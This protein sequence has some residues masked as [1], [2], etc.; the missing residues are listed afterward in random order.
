MEARK[1]KLTTGGRVSL[2]RDALLS[3]RNEKGLSQEIVAHMC[4]EQR[5]CV[6]IASLKRAET[7]KNILYRTARDISSF[8]DVALSDLIDTAS[9]ETE[10]LSSS[11]LNG[12]L[13]INAKRQIVVLICD[14]ILQHEAAHKD[15]IKVWKST[16]DSS[17]RD[18]DAS[19]IPLSSTRYAF[20]FGNLAFM[21][22]EHYQA[23]HCGKNLQALMRPT[24]GDHGIVVA[25]ISYQEIIPREGDSPSNQR[26]ISELLQ[27]WQCDLADCSE[28]KQDVIIANEPARQALE[29]RYSIS[30]YPAK[31]HNA[32]TSHWQIHED[33][34]SQM[35][36]KHFIGRELQLQQFKAAV[37]SVFAYDEMQLIYIRG[38]AGIGKTRALEAFCEYANGLGMDAHKAQVLDFGAEQN[39]TAI[40]K[41][42]RSILKLSAEDQNLSYEEL[43]Q[44]FGQSVCEQQD[45]IFL[46]HWLGWPLSGK[47]A[48]LYKTMDHESRTAGLKNVVVELIQKS[49]QQFP[50]LLCIEDLHWANKDLLESIQDLAEAIKDTQVILLMTSRRENDPMQGL[51]SSAWLNT[52]LLTMDLTPLRDTEATTFADY[53]D[54][55]PANYKQQCIQ[56]ADGNPLFLEQL[57]RA[58]DIHSENLPHNLQTLI[59]ARLD[60][61]SAQSQRAARAASVLGQW[62]TQDALDFV[63]DAQQQ[64]T[65][66]LINN[67]IVKH[68]G[69]R[70]QFVHALVQQGIYQTITDDALMELHQRC[71]QWFESSDI[72]LQAQHLDRARVKQA[73]AVYLLAIKHN[74]EHHNFDKALQLI[75]EAEQINYTDVD[76]SSLWRYK[77]E[78]MVATGNTEEAVACF[79]KSIA[80]A[81]T[82]HDKLSPLLSL[83]N[84]LD[85]LEQFEDALN[86]L[87][88]AEACVSEGNI[89]RELSQ[90]HYLR[91][92]LYFPR[93][94]VDYC[95]QEHSK[96]LSYAR[97]ANDAHAEAK[98]L[99]GLGDAAYAQGKMLSAYKHFRECL[100]LCAEFNLSSVEAANRLM[101]GTTRIYLNET[102]QALE[103]ALESAEIARTVGHKRAEIVSRL[104]AGWILLDMQSLSQASEQIER[105]LTLARDIGAKRFDPFLS[106][107]LARYHYY[108][109]DKKLARDIINKAWNDIQDQGIEGFIGPWIISCC[110]LL[111]E[112]NEEADALLKTGSELLKENCIGHNYYR[113]YVNAIESA[114]LRQN[115]SA[116]NNFINDFASYTQIEPAPWSDYYLQ[117]AKLIARAMQGDCSAELNGELK[118]I[119]TEGEQANLMHSIKL[120]TAAIQLTE[121]R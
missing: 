74:I 9:N 87:E 54:D 33:E 76:H 12:G 4:A 17:A 107:S 46:Y 113:F 103:D 30:R 25:Q 89:N 13:A 111:A 71:A 109:G 58:S 93:G 61:L 60:S 77:G 92:N 99:G 28:Q 48:S 102:Q 14:L 75:A 31:N 8:F 7:G 95:M 86:T 116:A 49:T 57:L 70:M 22:Y 44:R 24:L 64:D 118:A 90:I 80:S 20:V 112:D 67:Y 66:S 91:G 97:L 82:E 29:S 63:L 53:F 121:S 36:V 117:R 108:N 34:S 6:S 65:E 51:W 120:V 101:I 56:R 16:C 45:L 39:Q 1:K 110:A 41:L 18:F 119:K 2:N 40:P 26:H 115:F 59:L 62:F 105:G 23:I 42:I 50:L 69:D 78:A 72:S 88:Q 73:A 85:T 35:A 55:I 10:S 3:L 84:G 81:T 43:N 100:E 96:A 104:T 21:G 5:L 98:A 114:L 19:L 38:L 83:A 47:A 11:E 68:S 27:V 32:S 106:E 15:I 79:Q 52:P 37:E 94:Q